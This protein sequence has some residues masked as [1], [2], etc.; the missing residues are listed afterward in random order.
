MKEVKKR[1]S[2]ETKRTEEIREIKHGSL[3][4][5]SS[6]FQPLRW[7][8]ALPDNLSAGRGASEKWRSFK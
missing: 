8:T 6:T 3:T 1:D 2:E 5:P 4:P 7:M